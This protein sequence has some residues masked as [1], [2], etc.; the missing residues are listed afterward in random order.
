MQAGKLR[1]LVTL[2]RLSG[3]TD[4]TGNETETWVDYA[5]VRAQIE[6]WIDS[7]RSGR[8]EFTGNQRT[9]IVYT[10][11]RIRYFPGISPKDRVVFGSRTFD[12]QAVNNRD[13]RNFEIELICKERP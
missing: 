7:A 6:P 10:R 13:E 8:E 9:A 12:I 5:S 4:T 3:A 11:F 1:H 2:Q